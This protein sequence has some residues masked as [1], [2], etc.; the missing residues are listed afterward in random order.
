PRRERLHP[1]VGEE[2]VG[3]PQLIPRIKPA[4]LPSQP[5]PIEQMRSRQ[6]HAEARRLKVLD[7]GSVERLSP[8]SGREERFRA[9]FDAETPWGVGGARGFAQELEGGGGVVSSAAAAGGFDELDQGE[10]GEPELLWIRGRVRGRG[11]RV[12]IARQ[13]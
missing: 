11:E 5:L 4:A 12:L 7:R 13:P 9:R 2:L 10:G 8:V 6:V 1:E 3:D